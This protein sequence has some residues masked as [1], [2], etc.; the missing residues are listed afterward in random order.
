MW[1]KSL[2]FDSSFLGKAKIIA[3][4]WDSHDQEIANP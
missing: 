1:V 3:K 2:S 4:N